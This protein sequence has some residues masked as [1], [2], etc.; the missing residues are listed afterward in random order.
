MAGKFARQ[1]R[2]EKENPFVDPAGW[3]RLIVATERAFRA[4]LSLE[5][6]LAPR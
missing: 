1:D 6:S 5:R 3:R 4:Q 2:G